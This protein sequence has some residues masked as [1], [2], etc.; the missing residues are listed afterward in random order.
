VRP[1]S[2]LPRGVLFCFRVSNKTSKYPATYITYIKNGTSL[3]RRGGLLKFELHCA[4]CALDSRVIG[5]NMGGKL[6]V[7]LQ[8]E[9]SHHFIERFTRGRGRRIKPPGAIRA[10]KTAKT[11]FFDPYK[12]AWHLPVKLGF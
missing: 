11:V 12:L 1:V 8:L 5:A 10:S 3:T 9:V 4:F 6:F 7:A 2:K